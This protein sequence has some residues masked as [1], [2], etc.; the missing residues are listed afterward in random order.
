MTDP[1]ANN[2]WVETLGS[3][4]RRGGEAL[5]P[6]PDLLKRLLT[7]EA[8][9]CFQP[10]MGQLVE[11]QRFADFVTTPPL[12][13]LG[14]SVDLV[15]RIVSADVEALDLLDQAI[16]SRQGERTD[17][18][19]NMGEVHPKQGTSKDQA[20]RKLRKDAPGLHADVL[21]GRIS[22][23]AAM[24]KA[25]YRPRTFTVA[26]DRPDRIVATLRRQLDPETLAA[27]AELLRGVPS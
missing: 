14:T 11:H 10:R 24:V 5:D 27:V 7:D 18:S 23:H 19:N 20:L 4:L 13:G 22:A 25:G 3:S 17:L 8:W 6:V 9:R 1:K 15:R 21:A 16:A 26:A 12:G 2:V